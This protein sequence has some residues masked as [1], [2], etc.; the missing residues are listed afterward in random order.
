MK[1]K[2]KETPINKA[3]LKSMDKYQSEKITNLA[4]SNIGN[5]IARKNV[6][7]LKS[8]RNPQQPP[9]KKSEEKIVKYRK[10]TIEREVKIV[11]EKEEKKEEPKF[12]LKFNDDFNEYLLRSNK[13]KINITNVKEL[14][15]NRI[16][17]AFN[18]S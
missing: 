3:V 1:R 7:R 8:L 4:P 12:T 10:S 15:K 5:N 11:K 16:N 13:K 2:V 9:L 6:Y 14:S 17:S 18:Y